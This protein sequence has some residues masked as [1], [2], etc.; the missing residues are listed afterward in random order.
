MNL[1]SFRTD[2][3]DYNTDIDNGSGNNSALISK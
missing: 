1:E 3:H 2:I